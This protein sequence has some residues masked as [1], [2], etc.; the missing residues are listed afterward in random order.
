MQDVYL[1][2][3]WNNS[4]TALHSSISIT[5]QISGEHVLDK[6]SLYDQFNK[7][8]DRLRLGSVLLSRGAAVWN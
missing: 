8:F 5:L 7:M 1:R 3:I 6:W 2:I 4:S